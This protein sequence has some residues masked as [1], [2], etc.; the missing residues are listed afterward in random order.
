MFFLS[1][2]IKMI[3]CKV[4]CLRTSLNAKEVNGKPQKGD[5]LGVISQAIDLM[6]TIPFNTFFA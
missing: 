1:E 2:H 5:M 6:I 4:L 3:T